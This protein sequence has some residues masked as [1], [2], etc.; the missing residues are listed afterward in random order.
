MQNRKEFRSQPKALFFFLFSFLSLRGEEIEGDYLLIRA[1]CSAPT[2]RAAKKEG[3]Q[4]GKKERTEDI[5]WVERREDE[6]EILEGGDVGIWGL[7]QTS[8]VRE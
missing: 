7:R 5:R 1:I 4:R 8:P 6:N 3:M 2:R